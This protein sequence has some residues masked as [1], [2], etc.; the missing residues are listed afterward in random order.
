[1]AEVHPSAVVYPAAGLIDVARMEGADVIEVNLQKSA[2]SARADVHLLGP[3][4]TM[5]PELI[6][7]L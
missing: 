1:M 7:R 4:G 5:L 3:S 6:K 2:A